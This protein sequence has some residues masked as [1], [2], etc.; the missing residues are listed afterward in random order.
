M[1]TRS[2][3]VVIK[4]HKNRTFPDAFQPIKFKNDSTTVSCLLKDTKPYLE[5]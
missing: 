2:N 3:P 1:T 4:C 5:T